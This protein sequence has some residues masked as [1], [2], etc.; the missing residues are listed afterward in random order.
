MALRTVVVVALSVEYTVSSSLVLAM[1]VL[2]VGDII[3]FIGYVL[4]FVV[5]AFKL[6]GKYR[7]P[8]HD[9]RH[10]LCLEHIF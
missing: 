2:Y 7:N 8:L 10:P 6:H 3:A 9:D 4:T 1:G 5:G